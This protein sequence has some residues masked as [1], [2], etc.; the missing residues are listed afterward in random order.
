MDKP[1]SNYGAV[2]AK[3][4]AMGAADVVP[5]VSGGTIAFVTGIY[6]RII[7][8]LTSINPA[9]LKLLFSGRVAELWRVIDGSFLV[10]LLA[11]IL[12]S[13]FSLASI[14][15]MALQNYPELVWS[16]FYG[17]IIAST[18]YVIK[19]IGS[20]FAHLALPFAFGALIAYWITGLPANTGNGEPLWFFIAG[21]VAICAMI[22]PGISGSFIL[23]LMGM[24]SPML[25]AVRNLQTDLL[26]LFAAGCVT[27]LLGFSHLLHWLFARFKL[28]TLAMLTGFLL[29]SLRMLW[30]WKMTASTYM[31]SHGQLQPL[32]RVNVMPW[33]Y[34][35]L[36]GDSPM[37]L[38]CLLLCVLGVGLVFLLE[39]WS[40][41]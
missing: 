10:I 9:A 4:M 41:R 13:I 19:S 2:F 22:L 23:L 7:N 27:G 35:Q 38:P 34:Q 37:I 28:L 11:G 12:T 33:D 31:D 40:R 24:Y 39:W 6:E 16:F 30:P 15:S 8:A 17:L 20:W 14:V 3:G 18:I 21:S 25:D 32:H 29:G 26:T 36:V 5:G 1:T